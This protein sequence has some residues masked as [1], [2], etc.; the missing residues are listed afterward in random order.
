MYPRQIVGNRVRV[1]TQHEELIG[2]LLAVEDWGL[3]GG[4]D[5]LIIAVKPSSDQQR[6]RGK[7]AVS[8]RHVEVFQP[9]D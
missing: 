9:L 2:Q 8:M 4:G 1:R 3:C 5:Y 6:P 7:I